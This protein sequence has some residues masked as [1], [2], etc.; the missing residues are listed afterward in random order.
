ML[1]SAGCIG[2]CVVTSLVESQATEQSQS[3]SVL[4]RAMLPDLGT[5]ALG[6]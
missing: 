2:V 6:A 3:P 5:D 1:R 4:L